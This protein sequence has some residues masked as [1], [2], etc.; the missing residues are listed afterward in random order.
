MHRLFLPAAW[1]CLAAVPA[2]AGTLQL[3]QALEGSGAAPLIGEREPVR[4]VLRVVA[5]CAD[6]ETLATLSVAVADTRLAAEPAALDDAGSIEVTLEVSP[7]QLRGINERLLCSDT[8]GEEGSLKLLRGA[9]SATASARCAQAERGSRLLYA[10]TDVD[11][12][13]WCPGAD[14]PP[15]DG[16]AGR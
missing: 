8:A 5:A 3:E 10:S 9:F 11:V 12:S 4:F 15:E 1:V 2:A 7:R 13:Y 14:Q 6:D 16:D